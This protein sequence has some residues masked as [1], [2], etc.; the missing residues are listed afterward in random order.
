M[1]T[2]EQ[3]ATILCVVIVIVGAVI[4]AFEIA[5]LRIK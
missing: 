3:L 1:T 4:A 2:A 5:R